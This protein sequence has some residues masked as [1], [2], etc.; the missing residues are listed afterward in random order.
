MWRWSTVVTIHSG[1]SYQ[2]INKLPTLEVNSTSINS[3][4]SGYGKPLLLKHLFT[5]Y[6]A[7]DDILASLP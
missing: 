5:D 4:T 7:A 3:Q 1:C 2:V 6:R